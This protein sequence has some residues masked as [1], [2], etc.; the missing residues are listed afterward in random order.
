MHH[1]AWSERANLYEVNLRQYTP[2]GSFAA[3]E[4]HLPRLAEMGVDIL[5]LM[6]IHPIGVRHRKGRLGSPYAVRDHTAVNP[7]FGTLDDLRRLVEAAHALGMHVILDWV[8]HHT[9]WDHRWVAEHP[10]WYRKNERGEIHAYTFQGEHGPEHWADVVGLDYRQNAL[11]AAMTQALC[12]WVRE[13]G[14]D[15]YRCDVAGL[16]PTPFWVQARE[17]LEAIKPVFMLAE[18]SDPA[19]HDGAFDATF[20]W[21]LYDT[22]TKIAR[23]E[24]DARALDDWLAAEAAQGFPAHAYRL[25]FTTNHDKNSWEGHDGERFGS[26]FKAFAVLAATLPGMPLVYGGQ[27]AGLHKRLAFFDKDPIDWGELP[28]AD[29]YTGLLRLKHDNAALANGAA[30]GALVRIATGDDAMFAFRRAGSGNVVSVIANLSAQ[31]RQGLE[32]WGYRIEARR[33]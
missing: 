22:M 11:R 2:E 25:R 17:A 4:R 19:L 13:A 7:E 12:W 30:G 1:V 26:A 9:A 8:A 28:L 27:E 23:G 18:W 10:D 32:P 21:P 16:V 15:G 31:A 5:W 33:L 3:F 14:I 29:F 20:D 6:P 24:A